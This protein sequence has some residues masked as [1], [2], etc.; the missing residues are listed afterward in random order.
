[1]PVEEAFVG[2]GEPTVA[3]FDE[4]K[5]VWLKNVYTTNSHYDMST[6]FENHNYYSILDTSIDMLTLVVHR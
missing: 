5:K 6:L 4:Q 2:T 3:F 1:M